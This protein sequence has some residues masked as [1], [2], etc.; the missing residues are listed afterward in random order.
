MLSRE[1]DIFLHV[2]VIG[3]MLPV[4]FGIGIVKVIEF[5]RR[6]IPGV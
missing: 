5:H 2:V 6:E 3:R 1:V 4:G